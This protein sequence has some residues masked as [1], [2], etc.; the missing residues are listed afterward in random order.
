MVREVKS[1]NHEFDLLY[2]QRQSQYGDAVNNMKR[3][4]L[5]CEVLGIKVKAE[6][7]PKIMIVMKLVRDRDGK[8]KDTALDIQGYAKILGEV[9]R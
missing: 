5:I 9:F 4:S 6:D 8:L 3:V 7:I 2:S 1:N